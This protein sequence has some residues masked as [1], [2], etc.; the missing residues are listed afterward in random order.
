M[1]FAFD[2]DVAGTLQAIADGTGPM[3]PHRRSAISQADEARS[4]PCSIG[5]TIMAQPIADEVETLDY[6]VTVADGTA[7]LA[8][9]SRDASTRLS[10]VAAPSASMLARPQPSGRR[11]LRSSALGA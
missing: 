9:W 11:V 1:S 3:P 10:P 6:E 2:P 7:I 4:T 8:R 5:R